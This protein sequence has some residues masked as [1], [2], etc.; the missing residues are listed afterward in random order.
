M[1][2]GLVRALLHTP[3][4]TRC[5]DTVDAG[6]GGTEPLTNE[7]MEERGAGIDAG[8]LGARTSHGAESESLQKI[9]VGGISRLNTYGGQEK[10]RERE[11]LRVI[12]RCPTRWR[13][14]VMVSRAVKRWA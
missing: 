10:G 1:P 14:Q 5:R 7:C 12:L 11:K 9:R 2:W 4:L 3:H 6:C 8:E 13:K